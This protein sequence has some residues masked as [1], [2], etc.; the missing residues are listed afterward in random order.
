[1]PAARYIQLSEAEDKQLQAIE[2]NKGLAEKVRLRAKVVRLSHR[3][4]KVTE[5]AAY[6]GRDDGSILRDFDRWE[7]SGVEGLADGKSPGQASSLGEKEK[8]FMREK[9][10]EE[11]AWT[12]TTLAEEVNK[13]FKLSINRESMR[14][15]LLAMAYSWQRQR[16]VPVKTPQADVL[17]EAKETLAGFKKKR[18]QER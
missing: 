5:I 6:V 17:H 7:A 8:A 13:K 12:A 15:C 14:V 2:N 9:L 1:M 10:A 3:R 16:Y 11:R 4:M 18:K